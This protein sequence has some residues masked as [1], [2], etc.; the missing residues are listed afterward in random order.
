MIQ[1]SLRRLHLGGY[2]GRRLLNNEKVWLDRVLE[3]DPALF[4]VFRERDT[5]PRCIVPWF[6]EY[7]GKLLTGMAYFYR[8]NGRKETKAAGDAMVAAL[9][10]VQDADG[11]L[12]PHPRAQRL[13]GH[14][15]PDA[16][17]VFGWY[18]DPPLWD[19][20]GHY[21]CIYGLLAWYRATGGAQA[22]HTACRAADAVCGHFLGSGRSFSSAGEADKNLAIGHALV[23]LYRETGQRR[24]L[25]AAI[26]TVEEQK[27]DGCGGWLDAALQG[28]A[29]WQMPLHRWEALH[30]I[31]TLAELYR[32][33]GDERYARGFTRLWQSIRDFD[34]H[35]DGGFSNG[36]GAVGDP[37]RL[38]AVETC[39][40]VAWMALCVDRWRMAHEPAVLDELE[41]SFF[42]AAMGS[43]MPDD[44]IFTYDVPMNGL[45]QGAD[46]VLAWQTVEG[47][48]DLSCCQANGSRGL[49][50][51]VEWAAGY[52]G[53]DVFIGF[54]GPCRMELTGPVG[55]HLTVEQQ[56]DYPVGG[57][58]RIVLEPDEPRRFT[59]RLRIPGWSAHTKVRVCGGEP[60]AAESGFFAVTRLWRPGDTVELQLDMTPHFW[61]G[62]EE[63][64]GKT[65]VYH[66]P[67]LL[68]LDTGASGVDIDTCV[69]SRAALERMTVEPGRDGRW[70]AAHTEDTSGRSVTLCAFADGGRDGAWY[71]S[72]LTVQDPPQPP[73]DRPLWAAR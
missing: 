55:Q 46:T 15:H 49:G 18:N 59:L 33:T 9:S 58:V 10:D 64:A 66:G 27:K 5:Q 36:E 57:D 7:P 2:L 20:W 23:L 72:W 12:G 67:V 13:H 19:V 48:R 41:L 35:N 39:C 60:R 34:R 26:A 70:L 47:G 14:M 16:V 8:M 4:T 68:V 42:N 17:S 61:P 1:E 71:I 25:E 44:R 56:T 24:Y 69:F 3:D 63:M 51:V 32:E 28:Q 29:F 43:L 53:K 54:Y 21:H 11:Y 45:R 65:S 52:L 37:Y 31:E 22:L 62:R 40:T 30:A 73:Q 50:Q 6:G 38:G